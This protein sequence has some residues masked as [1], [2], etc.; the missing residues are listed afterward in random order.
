M[1]VDLRE[2]VS[3]V[4]RNVWL[5]GTFLSA[6]FTYLLFVGPTEVLLPYIV[7]TE[8]GGSAAA[9]GLILTSGGLGAIVAAVTWAGPGFPAASSPSCTSPGPSPPSPSPATAWPPPPGSSPPHAYSSTASRPPAPSPGPPRSNAWFPD[10]CSAASRAWT[11]SSPRHCCRC[12]TPRSAPVTSWIGVR[13]T[14][15]GAGVLGAVVTIGFLFLPG[16]RLP[17]SRP[18]R[19]GPAGTVPT[20]SSAWGHR[21]ERAPGG[22]LHR[23]PWSRR[24][25]I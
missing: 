10:D 3:Y 25:S 9:L 5:W 1:W 23:R 15:V 16:M 19:T 12:R 14:L 7:K 4:R 18:G 22:A 11:G 21:R 6:T 24:P 8:L 13:Q 17:E 20:A 2:G